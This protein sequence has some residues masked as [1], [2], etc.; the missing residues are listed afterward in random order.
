M[1]NVKNIVVSYGSTKGAILDAVANLKLSFMQILYAEPFSKSVKKELEGKNI[2]LVENNATGQL[3]KLIAE[4]TGIL[5][6]DNNK[7]L[8]YDGRPFLHDELKKEIEKRMKK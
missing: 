3:G 8:R 6:P 7:V 1:K 2:I 5:I 4:K